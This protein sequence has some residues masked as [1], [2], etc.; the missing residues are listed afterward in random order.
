MRKLLAALLTV[1]ATSPTF[2]QVRVEITPP[3]IVFEAPP[4]LVE[5]QP[6]V[7]VVVDHDEEVYFTGGWYWV[8]RGNHW[9]RTQ[10]HRGGWTL[11]DDT[12]VPV[13]LVKTPKGKYKHYKA[14]KPPKAP[15]RAIVVA[16]NGEVLEVKLKR[17]K[18]GKH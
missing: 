4:P 5:V 7:Q 8:R 10:D 15:K 13:I 14:A 6:G 11:A 2:A 3:S 17:G 12:G 9:F 18:K 1:T 16:P